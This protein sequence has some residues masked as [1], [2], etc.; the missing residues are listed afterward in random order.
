MRT[1][2]R[3]LLATP[4]LLTLAASASA[5][6]AW[7]LWEHASHATWWG[8][9]PTRAEWTPLGTVATLDACDKEH[10]R[11]TKLNDALTP[12]ESAAGRMPS[13]VAWR[14]LPDTVD[15]RGSK[16]K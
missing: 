6:C 8:W 11:H 14:G 16:G 10:A 12:L 13:Y 5:D 1:A 9:G 3:L 7:V 4:G 2:A 15:P